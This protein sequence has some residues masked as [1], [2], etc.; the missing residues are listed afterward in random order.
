V[1]GA[2]RKRGERG[3]EER[4]ESFSRDQNAD[5]FS[6]ATFATFA[7][8]PGGEAD[9]PRAATR[10]RLD[11]LRSVGVVKSRGGV[12]STYNVSAAFRE[13]DGRGVRR[14]VA[15]SERFVVDDGERSGQA[16]R[17]RFEREDR[18]V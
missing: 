14:F 7:E 18:R 5:A 6:R 13:R 10:R 17:S 15:V 12:P 8:A 2:K 1:G 11:L 4:F 16:R 9:A 3:G